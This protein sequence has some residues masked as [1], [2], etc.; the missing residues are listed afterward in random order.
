MFQTRYKESNGIEISMKKRIAQKKKGRR[1][2]KIKETISQCESAKHIFKFLHQSK[3]CK[4]FPNLYKLYQVFLTIPVTSA[5]AERAFSKLKI[6]KSYQRSTMN[7][8]RTSD[9]AI[10]SIERQRPIDYGLALDVFA[11]LKH[12][13]KEFSI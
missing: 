1:V 9:L 6:I 5:E 11:S 8:Q 10:I 3:L 2:F 13:R 7:Q 4:V 12:R